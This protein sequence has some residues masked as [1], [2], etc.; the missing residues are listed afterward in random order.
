M[1]SWGWSAAGA[2]DV[3]TDCDT[4]RAAHDSNSTNEI[5][6]NIAGDRDW[7]DTLDGRREIVPMSY[8][9]G[10]RRRRSRAVAYAGLLKVLQKIAN[11]LAIMLITADRVSFPLQYRAWP[12]GIKSMAFRQHFAAQNV[13]DFA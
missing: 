9:I 3:G 4:A 12:G 2:A 13:A 10:A 5:V 6:V 11:F 1:G 8:V 7:L